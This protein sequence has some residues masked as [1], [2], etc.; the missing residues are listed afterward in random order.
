MF[1]QQQTG[2]RAIPARRALTDD[3]YD[4]VLG[5]LM[6]RVIEPGTK[7]SIDGIARELA[8]SPTPVREALVRLESEGLVTKRSLKG[9]VAAELLDAEG[10]RQLFEMRLLLEPAAARLAASNPNDAFMSDLNAEAM[11]MQRESESAQFE[12][13]TFDGYRSFQDHDARF[14]A[15]IAAQSGNDLLRDSFLRLRAHMHIFRFHFDQRIAIE[16]APEHNV[17][18]DA[19]RQG[20]ADGAEHAMRSHV[21][22]SFERMK[23][24][25]RR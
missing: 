24:E 15:L 19:L 7:A 10:M 17:I 3:V 4:A 20:D 8:V 22:F 14:H 1:Q 25:L 23:L 6:D 11:A 5:L 12:D 2:S 13:A 9:Y 16:T 21:E 18:V